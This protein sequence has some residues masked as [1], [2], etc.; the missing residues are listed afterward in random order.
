MPKFIRIL[1]GQELLNNFEKFRLKGG[2][3]QIAAAIDGTHIKIKAPRD[4]PE[5]YFNHKSSYSIV[6]QALVDSN[7]RFIDTFVGMPGSVHDARVSQYPHCDRLKNNQLFKPNPVE[8]VEGCNI[9][10]LIIG[11]PAYPLL[12][13]L[14]RPFSGRGRLTRPQNNFNY[15]LSLTRMVV[16]HAFGR[17]K[18]RWRLLLKE[19][20]HELANLRHVVQACCTLHNICIS[21]C[22]PYRSC[23]DEGVE[24][25][26]NNETCRLMPAGEA[27]NIR[28]SIMA[29]L[30]NI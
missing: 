14:M 7:G 5:D 15:K 4:E 24:L 27:E 1:E 28:Q 6:V 29:Y 10:L 13:N 9:P 26:Q 20:E 18:G 12:P 2:F 21:N 8:V 11:D 30:G 23:W 3:P 25:I 19:N 16:E 17:L 22:V